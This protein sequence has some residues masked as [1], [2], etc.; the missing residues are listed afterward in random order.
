MSKGNVSTLNKDCVA[1]LEKNGDAPQAILTLMML[2]STDT[3]LLSQIVND[4]CK[5][6]RLALELA[7]IDFLAG[8]VL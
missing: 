5:H 3:I 4:L 6:H 7:T 1:C 2:L 8:R